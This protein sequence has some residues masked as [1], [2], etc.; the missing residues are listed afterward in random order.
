MTSN[1]EIFQDYFNWT[2]SLLLATNPHDPT[3]IP[4]KC[5]I[6]TTQN[7][8]FPDKPIEV[9]TVT[10]RWDAEQVVLFNKMLGNKEITF[11][12]ISKGAQPSIGTLTVIDEGNPPWFLDPNSIVRGLTITPT[13]LPGEDP[14]PPFNLYMVKPDGQDKDPVFISDEKQYSWYSITVNAEDQDKIWEA[15]QKTTTI[16]GIPFNPFTYFLNNSIKYINQCCN[17]NT[18]IDQNV[19]N[20]EKSCTE[21]GF[22]FDPFSQLP[23]PKCDSTMATFCAT[24]PNYNS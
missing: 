13:T 12:V 23:N 14:I 8:P 19:T 7:V 3:T 2:F 21:A 15:I 10:N 24:G 5:E 1:E 11:N 4:K 6:A 22:I 18:L 9:C 17:L 16:V 20:L